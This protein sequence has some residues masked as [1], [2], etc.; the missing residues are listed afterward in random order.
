[1]H[2]RGATADRRRL[3][4]V[5]KSLLIARSRVGGIESAILTG[6]KTPAAEQGHHAEQDQEQS[7]AADQV[8]GVDGQGAETERQRLRA[9]LHRRHGRFR[10]L[11]RRRRNRLRRPIHRLRLRRLV[12]RLRLRHSVRRLRLR[13]DQRPQGCDFFVLQIDEPI[14]LLDVILGF[15]ETP[16]E[17][18]ALAATRVRLPPCAGELLAQLLDATLGFG[19]TPLELAALAATRARLPP[20]AD[21]VLAQL[22]DTTLGFGET[23]PELAALAATRARLS[24]CA[25]ELLA[26]LLD[27]ALGFGETPPELA[28]LAAT[29]VHLPPCA[30]E[31]LAQ[32]LDVGIFFPSRD[33]LG[34]VRLPPGGARRRR[35][36]GGSRCRGAPLTMPYPRRMLAPNLRERS[37]HIVRPD[38]LPSRD[39]QDRACAQRVDVRDDECFRIRLQ[40]RQHHAL[41]A[42]GGVGPEP[43]RDRPQ[44][45]RRPDRSVSGP[46]RSRRRCGRGGGS[47]G[48]GRRLRRRRRR[49]APTRTGAAG[50]RSEAQLVP[51]HRAPARPVDVDEERQGRLDD[52]FIRTYVN[53]A[54]S[55]TPVDDG[56]LEAI[57]MFQPD[58]P[59]ELEL[60]R[61][62]EGNLQSFKIAVADATERNSGVQRLMQCG[63][64]LD[65][66]QLECGGG[67]RSE[68]RHAGRA[69]G[70]PMHHGR[71]SHHCPITLPVAVRRPSNPRVPPVSSISGPRPAAPAQS[72]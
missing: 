12:R 26:Q 48:P 15:G 71:S 47:A 3:A 14:Q 7:G 5:R 51:S 27:A 67:P 55:T 28:A 65:H 13:L 62:S 2:R 16:P 11:G 68:H 22:L 9:G 17:L 59:G 23:P 37:F 32:L 29:R 40:N 1:M 69:H 30:G 53:E 44:R 10:I 42:D 38:L 36:G 60:G 31:L 4:L 41:D 45:L 6:R 35:R 34:G 39:A 64:G 21:E 66:A 70:E 49:K 43:G 63:P 19:E 52:R 57:E 33:I 18:A 25:D 8:H 56:E 72:P 24:P 20:C 58:Y 50:G 61:R 46:A 54:G